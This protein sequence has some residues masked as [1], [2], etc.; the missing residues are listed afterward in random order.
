MLI[1]LIMYFIVIKILCQNFC[2]YCC[3][4]IPLLV[5]TEFFAS[6][7]STII[8]VPLTLPYL[9]LTS[10]CYQTLS[11]AKKFVSQNSFS[12]DKTMSSI[13]CDSTSRYLSPISN[14]TVSYSS[15]SFYCC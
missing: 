11:I 10:P 8:P 15:V 1:T 14:F 4:S 3:Y 12:T 2:S 6:T 5:V 13:T 9:L 7:I